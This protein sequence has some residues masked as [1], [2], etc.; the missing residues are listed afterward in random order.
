MK[1]RIGEQLYKVWFN[2]L[3]RGWKEALNYIIYRFTFGIHSK[4]IAKLLNKYSPF[5]FMIEFEPTTYC[6]LK[7]VMCEQSYWNNKA[8]MLSISSFVGLF[9]Q[10]KH[11]VYVNPTGIGQSFLNHEYFQMLDYLK[12]RNVYVELFDSMS[13]LNYVQSLRLIDIGINKIIISFD[14]ATKKTYELIRRGSSWDHVTQNISN[15]F[16]IRAELKRKIPEIEFHYIVQRDNYYETHRFIYLVSEWAEGSRVSIQFTEILHPFKEIKDLSVSINNKNKELLEEHGKRLG[17]TINFNRNTDHS[18]RPNYN[19]CTLW[20]MP[21][22]LV[23]GEVLPCCGGNENNNRDR[24][25]ELSLGNVFRDDFKTIWNG[26]KYRDLR[27]KL[28]N[29]QVPE[30]CVDCPVFGNKDIV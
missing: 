7:C 15:L 30:Y 8:S 23:T 28:L 10:F 18:K 29:N 17:I 4:F 26:T 20:M 16:R 21:F 14:A 22:I 12:G 25:I 11:I 13:Y 5:P 6:N 19:Q 3:E 27:S 2:L 1:L 24:Q 9:K